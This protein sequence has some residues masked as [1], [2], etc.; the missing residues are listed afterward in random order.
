[1]DVFTECHRI[2]DL[3]F[4]RNDADARN[5]V[6][7]LLDY[8]EKEDIPYSPLLNHLI[9]QTGL[10]PYLDVDTSNWQDRFVYESFKIDV[11]GHT[12]V[13]LH[14]EQSSILKKL[15]E[16]KNLAVS[17]PTSFGKSFIVDSFISINRPTNVVIIV[18]TIALTD[19]TRRRIQKS[20]LMNTRL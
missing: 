9:R 2:N 10:Y 12:P 1:M 5:G 17:A 19:E 13:T 20:F 16:G 14:R 4:Q 8:H 15:I 11:G 18:P 3:I 7:K 6:I